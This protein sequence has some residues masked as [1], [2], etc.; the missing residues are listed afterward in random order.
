MTA[1]V[2]GVTRYLELRE[3]GLTRTPKFA[4]CL[5]TV[6]RLLEEEAAKPLYNQP[7][8]FSGEPRSTY[9]MDFSPNKSR[10]ASTHGD[11]TV[12]VTDI[13]TGR[14]THILTGHP[15]TPWCLAFHPASDDIL[16]SGCLAGE[17]RIWDLLG[18]GSE[19]LQNPIAGAVITSLSFHPTEH[20]LVFSTM[21]RIHFWDW[22][23]PQP[24]ASACTSSLNERVRW[25]RF[26]PFGEILYTGISN[27]TNPSD[28]IDLGYVINTSDG[29]PENPESDSQE[30]QDERRTSQRLNRVRY[31]RLLRRFMA[32]QQGRTRAAESYPPPRDA[33]SPV[34]EENLNNARQFAAHVTRAVVESAHEDSV[35]DLRVDRGGSG[36]RSRSDNSAFDT[37]GDTAGASSAD[38]WPISGDPPSASRRPETRRSVAPVANRRWGRYQPSFFRQDRE[39][40]DR[41]QMEDGN[42]NSHRTDLNLRPGSGGPSPLRDRGL[43]GHRATGLP[44]DSDLGLPSDRSVGL[45]SGSGL[46]SSASSTVGLPSCLDLSVP[47]ARVTGAP[48]SSEPVPS[49]MDLTMPS[50]NA[51]PPP[52]SNDELLFQQVANP[53]PSRRAVPPYVRLPMYLDDVTPPTPGGFEVRRTD[54][55][56]SPVEARRRALGLG[57]YGSGSGG[58]DVTEPSP[59]RRQPHAS[60]DFRPWA[61]TS[62][63]QRDRGSGSENFLEDNE[64]EILPVDQGRVGSVEQGQEGEPRSSDTESDPAM[65]RLRQL[66]ASHALRRARGGGPPP[67]MTLSVYM[68]S[69]G[70]EIGQGARE[71]ASNPIVRRDVFFGLGRSGASESETFGTSSPALSTQIQDGGE[72]SVAMTT[73]NTSFL[74]RPAL[75]EDSVWRSAASSRS[76]HESPEEREPYR[77][78]TSMWW[79]GP[80]RSSYQNTSDDRGGP[81]QVSMPDWRNRRRLHG[82]SDG[83]F[84]R[85]FNFQLPFARPGSPVMRL[86]RNVTDR[87]SQTFGAMSLPQSF[88]QGTD[89]METSPVADDLRTRHAQD[90]QGNEVGSRASG[91]NGSASATTAKSPSSH[92]SDPACVS[93]EHRGT[94]FGNRDGSAPGFDT[95]NGRAASSA[96]NDIAT[97]P[98]LPCTEP[99]APSS[100][101]PVLTTGGVGCS[102]LSPIHSSPPTGTVSAPHRASDVAPGLSLPAVST[103]C[104][105]SSSSFAPSSSSTS[106]SSQNSSHSTILANVPVSCTITTSS[107]QRHGPALSPVCRQNITLS[108]CSPPSQFVLSDGLPSSTLPVTSSGPISTSLY[109]RADH[110]S[111]YT[112][113]TSSVNSLSP[114]VLMSTSPPSPASS[115]S[116]PAPQHIMS[117]TS[118]A[119]LLLSL[120]QSGRPLFSSPASELST[121]AAISGGASVSGTSVRPTPFACATASGQSR[122][123][124]ETSV[125]SLDLRER[126]RD[127]EARPHAET[128]S[129]TWRRRNTMAIARLTHS[130]RNRTHASRVLHE[131][132]LR[133]AGVTSYVGRQYDLEGSGT[134]TMHVL[135][136]L[137]SRRNSE[138]D[139][140]LASRDSSRGN[141][142][143]MSSDIFDRA[144]DTA[145]SAGRW[146]RRNTTSEAGGSW[147]DCLPAA[148]VEGSVSPD[149]SDSVQQDSELPWQRRFPMRGDNSSVEDTQH[150]AASRPSS[151]GPSGEISRGADAGGRP[152]EDPSGQSASSME[153]MRD[154]QDR[155]QQ[156]VQQLREVQ[157]SVQR[158]ASSSGQPLDDMMPTE[159]VTEYLEHRVSELDRRISNLEQSYNTRLRMCQRALLHRIQGIRERR[160][161]SHSPFYRTG[162]SRGRQR[163]GSRTEDGQEAE[164]SRGGRP[165]LRR[166]TKLTMAQRLRAASRPGGLPRY[167]PSTPSTSASSPPSGGHQ[168]NTLLRC[169]RQSHPASTSSS[170]PAQ[171]A[172]SSTSTRP[173]E[174]VRSIT[175]QAGE[176]STE[177]TQQSW[178]GLRH[179]HLHP[180]Y[181]HSILDDAVNRPRWLSQN[182][183]NNT[184]AQNFLSREE[185]A[186]ANNIIPDTHRI[187]YWDLRKCLVPDISDSKANVIVPHCKLHNDASVDI[188]QDGTLLTTIVPSLRGFPDGNI[189]A[190]FS[191]R[192]DSLAQC[193]YTKK[194]GPNAISVSLSPKNNFVMVGLASKRYFYFITPTMMVAQVYQLVKQKAGERSMQHVT[195]VIHP[196][197]EPRSHVSVNSG[198]FLPGLGEGLVY[199]TNKGDLL[200]CR[201][202]PRKIQDTEWTMA[203]NSSHRR[204]DGMTSRRRNLARTNTST[205][206]TTCS[207]RRTVSTQTQQGHA[208]ERMEE[209]DS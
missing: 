143:L 109:T 148:R 172:S 40:S 112:S 18:G 135:P 72:S 198:R 134:E 160:I 65:S 1:A 22:H 6:E 57:E 141:D 123:S 94:S 105:S 35:M 92:G 97:S 166:R 59:G 84:R 42:N 70:P 96:R 54:A 88:D 52:A 74:W 29:N 62:N 204:H 149:V 207:I 176:E 169:L 19:V 5:K 48:S 132:E 131:Q 80:R 23:K 196:N 24:F 64:F 55:L 14:C 181:S 151:E 179:V 115:S 119:C 90:G 25:I 157:S 150:A 114:Q 32:F 33:R 78:T 85:S 133:R 15:R 164:S 53:P 104:P 167:T 202:G 186:V 191:L 30:S 125:N 177:R 34:H 77:P 63:E 100:Q 203:T 194:F 178:Q 184:I 195:D 66:V 199:G 129:S 171:R 117:V 58:S 91:Q 122:R 83:N 121:V 21:N 201:P 127:L 87:T 73:A 8:E 2:V 27:I 170:T 190:V 173:S 165:G 36:W 81:Y 9:L 197:R 99:H 144:H 126:S 182:L 174:E 209:E 4:K 98:G 138:E 44:S 67:D 11:H 147:P 120:N 56:F 31:R 193:L 137:G 162:L 153:T 183:M 26:D 192:P 12:R 107:P 185:Y 38:H 163:P 116:G 155:L 50:Q 128:P 158:L 46:R 142:S 103:T 45:P 108:S 175:I 189:L 124:A 110:S 208:E 140:P 60:L 168:N 154:M 118:A 139:A 51:G 205:Q 188:S 200:F 161:S 86:Y 68:P 145:P 47:S 16:A 113:Q 106:L 136:Q 75:T 102:D 89:V 76:Q 20:L 41:M 156:A 17:V 7:C 49:P 28:D 206:T 111:P 3:L 13:Q 152:A 10:I 159:D 43:P 61:A 71:P 95:D 37:V 101:P 146:G 79:A 187:Q 130:L 82:E 69:S 39:T 180:D 93:E